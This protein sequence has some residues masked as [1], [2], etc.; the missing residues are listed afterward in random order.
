MLVELIRPARDGTLRVLRAA[1]EAGVRRVVLTSS[2]A[3]IAYGE[4]AD[5]IEAALQGAVELERAD[6]LAHAVERAAALARPGDV[7]L[8]A[9]A[10]ASFDEFASF[11]ERGDA[12]ADRARALPDAAGD[13]P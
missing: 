12:F 7:V 8:L 4:C 3:A 13:R 6:D 2:G 1:M 9:P 5:A 11:E 10:C